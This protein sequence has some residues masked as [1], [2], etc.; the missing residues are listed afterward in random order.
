MS[1]K[2][3]GKDYYISLITKQLQNE[4]NTSELKELN[5][6]LSESSTNSELVTDFK[7]IWSTV[8]SY[9]ASASFDADLAYTNFLKKY[10]I[11]FDRVEVPAN[12]TGNS[13]GLPISRIFLAALT[14]LALIIGGYTLSK[15]LANSVSNDTL[16]AMELPLSAVS[17]ATVAP[18]TSLSF[19][20][21][22]FKLSQLDGQV[23]L[24]LDEPKGNQVLRLQFPDISANAN[25]ASFNLQ[26]FSDD[27]A[28][29]ADVSAGSVLFQIANKKY[30]LQEGNRLTYNEDTKEVLLT[31]ADNSAFQWK[32]GILSFDDTPLTE[33]FDKIEKFYGVNITVEKGADLDAH[34]TAA[35]LKA[36]TLDECLEILQSSIEMTIKR[37]GIRDFFISD[38][39]IK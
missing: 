20:K 15:K 30:N 34:F 5:S 33:V 18:S 6:W 13:D 1:L 27:K 17:S 4:L 25:N 32:K 24:N 12:K 3:V 31:E 9:K 11:N 28:F 7:S 10:K 38:I 8:S 21:N 23:Y 39:R 36:P 14:T 22:K 19:D 37:E 2:Y 29:V 35:N 16:I 26:R